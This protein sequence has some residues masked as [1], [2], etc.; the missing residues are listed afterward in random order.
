[1]VGF[2]AFMSLGSMADVGW[3]DLIYYLGNDPK[4]RSILIYMEASATPAASSP[5]PVK[6]P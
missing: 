2:S 4:T 6:S 1:M 5:P 3:G